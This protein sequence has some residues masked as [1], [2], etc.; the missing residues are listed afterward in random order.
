MAGGQKCLASK[1]ASN[2]SLSMNLQSIILN[3]HNWKVSEVFQSSG[4]IRKL[5]FLKN[6][7]FMPGR[8]DKAQKNCILRYILLL[9]APINETQFFKNQE[10]QRRAQI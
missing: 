4:E 9:T 8:H 7:D 6:L 2:L 5:N 10:E 3:F 1:V